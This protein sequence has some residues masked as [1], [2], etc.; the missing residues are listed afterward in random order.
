MT[1]S[2]PVRP[3]L[4]MGSK[5]AYG[6]GQIG[7]QVL[8]D[9]PALL[10]P[11]YLTTVLS[12][13]AW[14]AALSILLPK[15]WV[16]FCDPL[17]GAWSDRSEGRY[18]RAPFLLAGAVLSGLTFICLFLTPPIEN[19]W[20]AAGWNTLVFA[21]ASTAYSLFSVPYLALPAEMSADPHERTRILAYRMAFTAI[22]LFIGGFA[23]PLTKWLGGG[24]QSFITM[25]LMLGGI[26]ALTMLAPIL[27]AR[28]ITSR[29][30]SLNRIG[31]L[32]QV[33]IAFANRDFATLAIA[34]LLKSLSQ[35][36]IF[37]VLGLF[38]IYVVG[39]VELIVLLIFLSSVTVILSQPWWVYA[40]RRWGK[41]GGFAM[42]G[43]GWALLNLSWLFA[44]RGTDIVIAPPGIGPLS[45]QD[46]LLLGRGLL[47]GVFNSGVVLLA[48]SILSDIIENDRQISGEM[49]GGVFSGMFTAIE[50]VGFAAGPALAGVV[51]SLSGFVST[52]SG[53]ADQPA[54]AITGILI[55]MGAIPPLLTAIATA[56][57]VWNLTRTTTRR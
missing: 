12:V 28:R 31:V 3:A 15:A 41:Q 30:V 19:I 45:T 51:L 7:G 25:A 29:R 10:L 50:K 40:S 55:S 5:I 17:V 26:S 1:S 18:G 47:L 20:F 23:Q 52:K 22:G 56:L 21:I 11:I 39:R 24:Q 43:F 34:F 27:V 54:S 44:S 6:T 57:V 37:T 35:A 53:Q 2:P 8:R 48:F 38:F 16:V 46:L 49:R 9:A 36:C 13:P 14:L 32:A 42:A 4:G 33:R